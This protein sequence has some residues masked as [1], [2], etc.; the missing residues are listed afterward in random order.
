MS[1]PANDPMW[2]PSYRYF[3]AAAHFEGKGMTALAR[4]MTRK[5]ND[6]LKAELIASTQRLRDRVTRKGNEDG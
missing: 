5:G 3:R 6:A 1:K 2:V 4:K